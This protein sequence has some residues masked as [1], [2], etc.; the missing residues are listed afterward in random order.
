MAESAIQRETRLRRRLREDLGFFMEKELKIRTKDAGVRPF[1]MNRA[2]RLVHDRLTKQIAETG[3]VRAII[4]KG[5]QQGVSTY[6]AARF[7][8]RVI[9]RKGLKVFIMTHQDS[10][11]SNLFEMVQRYH[12][13]VSDFVRPTAGISNKSELYFERISSGYQVATA[14]TAGAGRSATIQLFHGS[15]VAFWPHAETHVAGA[16]QAISDGPGTEVILESTANGIGS[17]FHRVWRDAEAGES[18]FIPIF[19]PWTLQ[20]EYSERVPPTARFNKEEREFQKVYKLTDEQLY[21][22]QK[23]VRL[24]GADGFRQEYPMTADEAF[25]D[26]SDRP[27]INASAVLRARSNNEEASGPLIVGLDPAGGGDG[28][29]RTCVA[30]RVGRKVL[31]IDTYTT[32]D[33]MQTAGFIKRLVDEEEPARVF[34]DANGIGRGVWD[35]I[36][37]WGPPYSRIVVPIN[38]QGKPLT[39]KP[40]HGAGFANRRVEM[41]AAMKDWLEDE[42]DV[43]IPSDDDLQAELVAPRLVDTAS[44]QIQ[45]ENKRMIRKRRNKKSIDLADAMA[46]TF[47]APVAGSAWRA[48]YK[49]PDDYKRGDWMR[50]PLTEDASPWAA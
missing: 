47:A 50:E 6:V 34:L 49:G 11:T 3:K 4:L 14:G 37:E 7:Y 17:F 21:W 19:L 48:A 27:F 39:P 5:R 36:K 40:S 10:A 42:V 29:D 1:T 22:R 28:G 23:K 43:D 33:T 20:D 16:L 35:R 31:K 12:R 41:W 13:N 38:S 9:H 30:F 18:D 24:L 46:L 15:E 45:L 26:G 44:G 2:Q 32:F 8:H 25:L